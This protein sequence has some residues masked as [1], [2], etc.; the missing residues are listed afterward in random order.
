MGMKDI[1]SGDKVAKP[2]AAR[3]IKTEKGKVGIEVAFNFEEPATG[4][5]E[6]LPW[7]GWMTTDKVK[8]LTRDVLMDVLG[9]NGNF[10]QVN[11]KGEFKDP[12]FLDY[13]KEVKLVVEREE[14]KDESGNPK[15]DERGE[16]KTYPKIQWVNSLGGSN[17]AGCSVQEMQSELSWLKTEFLARRPQPQ[18]MAPKSAPKEKSKLPF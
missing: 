7:V 9:C 12:N 11:E 6:T 4:Q 8:Q 2:V 17:Y 18:N 1:M 10:D 16:V 14:Q 3:M 15:V 5:R 13:E